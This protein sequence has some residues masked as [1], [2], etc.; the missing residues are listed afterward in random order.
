[1]RILA[2]YKGRCVISLKRTDSGKP[3]SPGLTVE[4]LHLVGRL[5]DECSRFRKHA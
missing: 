2:E 1:M 5:T 3:W 4:V